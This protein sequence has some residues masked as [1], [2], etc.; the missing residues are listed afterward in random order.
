MCFIDFLWHLLGR[1]V[2]PL[3]CVLEKNIKKLDNILKK[4]FGLAQVSGSNEMN[5]IFLLTIKPKGLKESRECRIILDT[6]NQPDITIIQHSKQK[7]YTA[8][9]NSLKLIGENL[10]FEAGSKKKIYKVVK[11]DN[12]D[13]LYNKLYLNGSTEHVANTNHAMP[14]PE[15]RIVGVLPEDTL[16]TNNQHNVQTDIT[17]LANVLIQQNDPGTGS[18]H[19]IVTAPRQSQLEE[20]WPMGY[21]LDSIFREQSVQVMQERLSI[22]Q[23]SIRS[24]EEDGINRALEMSLQDQ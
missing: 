18:N 19:L 12:F 14:F 22:Y 17:N 15:A 8:N 10:K 13:L 6:C 11:N 16:Q 2:C 21:Q 1:G 7:K 5:N 9:I 3:L 20:G 4:G 23:A 24:L